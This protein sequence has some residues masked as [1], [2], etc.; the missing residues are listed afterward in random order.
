MTRPRRL[1]AGF[2]LAAV[3]VGH[4]HP[5]GAAVVPPLAPAC[6]APAG[7]AG[8]PGPALPAGPACP[9][10]SVPGVPTLPV[11]PGVP[12]LPSVGGVVGAVSG[13]VFDVVLA[14][15]VR[16]VA[17]GAASILSGLAALLNDVTA[18]DVGAAW[19]QTHYI[20]MAQIA[21]LLV[22]P[23][24]FA[25]AITAIV[26]QDGRLLLRAVAFHLPVAIFGTFM[27][28][29]LVGLALAVTDQ[30]CLVVLHND[31]G[32]TTRFLSGMG[33]S[34]DG[35]ASH[36]SVA[37]FAV[38]VVA[39]VLIAG[40]LA[41]FLELLMRTAAIYVAVL[42]LPIVL[43]GLVWPPTLRWA[44]RLVELLAVL[45]L[46]KFIIVAVLSLAASALAS[47][48]G[49]ADLAALLA[50]ASLLLL[51]AFAPYT[52]LRLAPIVEGAAAGHLEGVAT[53]LPRRAG[54]AVRAPG[55]TI[56]D[57]LAGGESSEPPSTVEPGTTSGVLD[58]RTGE[59]AAR[60]SSDPSSGTPYVADPAAFAASRG[61]V[62]AAPVALAA[63]AT[64]ATA[65]QSSV[66]RL[67]P[68]AGEG[69]GD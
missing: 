10:L 43:A 6:A 69:D 13:P 48:L 36:S 51:T 11:V 62:A 16:W 28:T 38:I 54:S 45:V 24:L 58:T 22:L 25:A 21:V 63:A 49:N 42:F 60:V 46:S 29:Q 27:A 33:T 65:A 23:L 41:V 50:G 20:V 57:L 44:R 64:V 8:A 9:Y 59:G 31:K 68:V 32:G 26:R 18:P 37:G 2:T 19:F 52:L 7:A 12:G 61:A 53:A 5:A 56:K 1:L 55:D 17:S 4:A 3:L 30:L 35:M 14:T 66:D 47:G 67:R 40:A 39:V 15:M 34:V